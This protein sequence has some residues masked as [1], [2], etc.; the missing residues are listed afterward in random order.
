MAE[1][2]PKFENLKIGKKVFRVV[3][4]NYADLAL[5]NNQRQEEKAA[6]VY[7]SWRNTE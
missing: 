1:Q 4:I 3:N 7:T 6:Q 5:N 2:K